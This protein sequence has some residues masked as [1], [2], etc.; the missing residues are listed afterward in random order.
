MSPKTK[1]VHRQLVK[2][3]VL[4]A[5]LPLLDTMAV[6]CYAV[7]QFEL[8]HSPIL[9]FSVFQIAGLV[10]VISPYLSLYFVSPY[11]RFIV[12]AM[13]RRLIGMEQQLEPTSVVKMGPIGPSQINPTIIIGDGREMSEI[14]M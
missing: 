7:E 1:E 6:L 2:A 10:P 12:S 3:L 14:A 4:Q 13:H 11:R 8:L 5:C 9:E